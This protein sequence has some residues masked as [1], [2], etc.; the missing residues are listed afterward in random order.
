M[1]VFV[2]VDSDMNL[3]CGK[4]LAGVMRKIEEDCGGY[5]DSQEWRGQDTGD[6]IQKNFH[7]IHW[8]DSHE[9]LNTIYVTEEDI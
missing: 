1:R 9:Q 2:G 5:L 6:H 7:V 4:D 3:W 8:M